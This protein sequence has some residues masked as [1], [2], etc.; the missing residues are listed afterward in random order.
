MKKQQQ[1]Q[2]QQKKKNLKRKAPPA[3]S[4]HD[5]KQEAKRAAARARTAFGG[6]G[7]RAYASSAPLSD[8]ERAARQQMLFGQAKKRLPMRRDTSGMEQ[9]HQPQPARPYRQPMPKRRPAADNKQ[10]SWFHDAP[11]TDAE[12]VAAVQ[13]LLQCTTKNARRAM[14]MQHRSK[15]ST[16]TISQHYK[17]L[18]LLVHP[19]KQMQSSAQRVARAADA[20]KVLVAA[21]QALKKQR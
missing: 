5:A 21:Y 4:S 13:H 17:R 19:D 7:G 1:Q 15:G 9:P 18:A 3:L 2:Q 12:R 8:S 14:C 16:L 6:G 20:F 11:F 10:P